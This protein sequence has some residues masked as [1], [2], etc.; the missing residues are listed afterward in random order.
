MDVNK[1]TSLY[2][3]LQE[4]E[5]YKYFEEVV[6]SYEKHFKQNEKELL[7]LKSISESS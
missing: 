1:L 7:I 2:E 3:N 6:H 5:E 4:S